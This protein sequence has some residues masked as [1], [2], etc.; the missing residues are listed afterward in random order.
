MNRLQLMLLAVLVGSSLFLVHNAYESRRLFSANQR[1]EEEAVRLA[2][3][4]KRLDAQRQLA[5]THARVAQEAARR[6]QMHKVAQRFEV[7][8]PAGFVPSVAASSS[9]VSP[10]GTASMAAAAASPQGGAR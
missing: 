5:A 2:R 7:P 8:A 3:E 6:L 4:Y 1:A 10:A 9:V